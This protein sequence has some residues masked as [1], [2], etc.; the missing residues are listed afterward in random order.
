M[1]L[2]QN[3]RI[4]YTVA[5]SLQLKGFVIDSTYYSN[6]DPREQKNIEGGSIQNK[7]LMFLDFIFQ[8]LMFF[9]FKSLKFLETWV[10]FQHF[11][12]YKS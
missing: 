2:R 7:N 5:D 1:E 3:T 10:V 4:V 9:A 6:R 12:A 8:N 11:I